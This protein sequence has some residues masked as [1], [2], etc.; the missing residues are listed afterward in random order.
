VADLEPS[1]VVER[2][3]ASRSMDELARRFAQ[4]ISPVGMTASA[5]GMVLGPRALSDFPFHFVNWPADWL[6]MYLGRGFVTIDPIPRWAM[7]SGEAVSWS[8]VL[9]RYPPSDPAWE[10]VH[11]AQAHGFHEGFATPIRTRT[12][13]LGLVG[14]AGGARPPFRLD[15]RIFLQV[16]SGAALMRAEELM[17]PP[18]VAASPFTLREQE[19]VALLRQGFTDA[20]IAAALGIALTTVRAHLKNARRKAGVRNRVELARR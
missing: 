9:A 18:T 16:A 7:V 2:L 10:V 5:C 6:E 3:R 12:G 4:A 13:A 19:C 1:P 14:V 17:A 11:A 15:E 20:E 8:E